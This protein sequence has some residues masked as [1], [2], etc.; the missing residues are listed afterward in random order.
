MRALRSTSRDIPAGP[1]LR[2]RREIHH[3]HMPWRGVASSISRG[4]S[5]RMDGAARPQCFETRMASAESCRR[6]RAGRAAAFRRAAAADRLDRAGIGIENKRSASARCARLS[7]HFDGYAAPL[8]ECAPAPARD[9]DA[10]PSTNGCP[11]AAS[12]VLV[13]RRAPRAA[14]SVGQSP[15]R[16]RS[17]RA[18]LLTRPTRPR[19]P[20]RHALTRNA[21]E[22]IS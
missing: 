22:P 9:F 11:S 18:R 6:C 20:G 21:L 1:P 7:E 10:S 2:H 16:A 8:A 5:F 3:L 14:P 17:G 4:T 12:P 15:D 19:R 13:A